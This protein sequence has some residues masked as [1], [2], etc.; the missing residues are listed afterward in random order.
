MSEEF[1]VF[2]DAAPAKG[3]GSRQSVPG[4][5]RKFRPYKKFVRSAG[6][7]SP[8]GSPVRGAAGKPGRSSI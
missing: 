7:A 1:D 8:A 6:P 5:A 2:A 3:N 4:K